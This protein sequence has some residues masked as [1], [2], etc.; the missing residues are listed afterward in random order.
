MFNILFYYSMDL[1]NLHNQ[2]KSHI[3]KSTGYIKIY[4]QNI[5]GLRTKASELIGHLHPDYPHALCITEHHFKK[6]QIKHTII[7]NY[8]LGASY[9]REQYEKGGVTI[10]IHKNIQ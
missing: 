9:C 1:D 5:R 8:N 7:E 6:F 4:Y 2:N 10:Y 3:D